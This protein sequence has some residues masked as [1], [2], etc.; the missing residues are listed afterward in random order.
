M[1]SISDVHSL[2][3]LSPV[4]SRALTRRRSRWRVGQSRWRKR[5]RC[6]QASVR[7]SHSRFPCGGGGRSSAVCFAYGRLGSACLLRLWSVCSARLSNAPLFVS[8][9]VVMSVRVVR[10]MGYRTPVLSWCVCVGS[11]CCCVLQRVVCVMLV[12]EGVMFVG[13]MPF[14]RG[15]V[16]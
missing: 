1:S 15:H 16:V 13:A 9:V 5:C 8:G 4:T 7:T 14:C 3:M 10:M 2:C 11:S 12:H 6:R